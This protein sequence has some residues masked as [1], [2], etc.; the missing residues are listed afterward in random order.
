MDIKTTEQEILL[1]QSIIGLMLIVT[2]E[3]CAYFI[4][5]QY[6]G[7]LFLARLNLFITLVHMG[8]LFIIRT[9]TYVNIKSVVPIYLVFL[10][11]TISPEVI[12]FLKENQVTGLLWFTTVPLVLTL[13]FS[14]EQGFLWSLITL[15][16]AVISFLISPYILEDFTI[17]FT[18][19]QQSIINFIGM[20]FTFLVGSFIFYMNAKLFSLKVKK[21][22]ESSK[23]ETTLDRGEIE[24]YNR[25]YNDIAKLFKEQ[26]LY[27]DPNLNLSQLAI[28]LNTNTNY[29][30]QAIQ[31]NKGMNFSTF[32]NSYRINMI[33]EMIEEGLAQKYT[34]QYIY[35]SAGFEH[36]TT[37]NKVFKRFE[38]INPSDY[39]TQ[40][41]KK[42]IQPQEE[43]SD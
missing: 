2:G 30:S 8:G 23:K 27:K 9:Y 41:A 7:Y 1:K 40:K 18:K 43:S 35:T 28:L 13:F 21:E 6:V 17:P 26:E 42:K 39:I 5:Y 31:L 11:L 34:I 38:G 33:K 24:K 12:L 4:Y 36:Q 29:I 25:L 14:P 16:L 37:F 22:A 32:V 15:V 10:L 3:T 20:L 19:G